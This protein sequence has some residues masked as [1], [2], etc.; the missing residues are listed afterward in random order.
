[1]RRY[2]LLP[3]LHF[4]FSVYCVSLSCLPFH[5]ATISDG[6]TLRVC[7]THFLMIPPPKTFLSPSACLTVPLRW[8][9]NPA[10]CDPA[11]PA[12]DWAMIFMDQS[13]SDP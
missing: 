12:Q 6:L 3:I 4:L 7:R 13:A 5:Q 8:F 1:M 10:C 11:V 2:I 9:L